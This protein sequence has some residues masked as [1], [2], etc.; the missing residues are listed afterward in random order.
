MKKTY[1]IL[2]TIII[3]TYIIIASFEKTFDLYHSFIKIIM[4]SF[5]V[6]PLCILLILLANDKNIKVPIRVLIII[7]TAIIIV[8]FIGASTVEI[9]Q[10]KLTEYKIGNDFGAY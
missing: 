9:I 4:F 5:F 6:I 1:K 8:S 2:I 10:G 3:S 7:A